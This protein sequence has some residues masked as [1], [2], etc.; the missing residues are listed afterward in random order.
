MSRRSPFGSVRQRGSGR[1]QAVYYFDGKQ[2]SA[3][4][5]NAKADAWAA[6]SLIEADLRRG[7]LGDPTAGRM[8]LVEYAEMWMKQKSNLSARTK[9]LYVHVLETQIAP[10]LG[11]IPLAALTSA[12]VRAWN[13]EISMVHPASAAKAY[14]LLSSIMKTAVLDGIVSSS[15]CRVRGAGVEKV[16]DRP[17]ASPSDIRRLEMEMPERLRIAVALAAWCQLRRGEVLGLRRGDIDIENQS[18]FVRHNRTFTMAGVPIEK[19]PKSKAGNRVLA[20]PDHLFVQL[21][22]HLNKYV[23]DGADAYVVCDM[24]HLP[25]SANSLHGHWRR[26]R[27]RIGRTDLRFHDLRHAGLT[28]AAS[29]GATTAELMHRAGHA[30][31]AAAMRYQH[32]LRERDRRVAGSLN[33]VIDR[34]NDQ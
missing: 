32:A 3:G 17:V 5:F 16:S 25:I 10:K 20:V 6:L 23:S 7:V 19:E 18:I 24:Q 4:I 11:H 29:T 27:A 21:V 8:S 2:T 26:A 31:P 1:W 14:R 15:P 9:E 22:E 34:D 28:Y 12:K 30:S 33:E 13:A